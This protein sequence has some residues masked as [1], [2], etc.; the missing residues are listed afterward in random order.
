[1]RLFSFRP[2]P[3]YFSVAIQTHPARTKYHKTPQLYCTPFC[4]SHRCRPLP[5]T[6]FL[7]PSMK[8]RARRAVA[9]SSSVSFFSALPL[10]R[11]VACRS[12]MYRIAVL[13]RGLSFRGM[14]G[15]VV[16]FSGVKCCAAPACCPSISRAFDSL[17][18]LHDRCAPSSM[19]VFFFICLRWRVLCM[20]IL[21]FLLKPYGTVRTEHQIL[22]P[23]SNAHNVR[24]SFQTCTRPVVTW[25]ASRTTQMTVSWATK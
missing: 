21:W 7:L 20:Y 8:P 16:L 14:R 6:R 2:Y 13:A 1:M 11:L 23:S 5:P 17:Q 22:N 19:V 10:L 3:N 24:S 25:A 12:L 18:H 15:V 4:P 9:S